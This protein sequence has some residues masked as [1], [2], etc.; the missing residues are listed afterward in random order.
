MVWLGSSLRAPSIRALKPLG[1]V[2]DARPQPPRRARTLRSLVLA[3]SICPASRCH[4]E[5]FMRSSRATHFLFRR[6]H[7]ESRFV[8]QHARFGRTTRTTASI[9]LIDPQMKVDRLRGVDVFRKLGR[10]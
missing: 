7:L 5:L 9:A 4:S 8:N 6:H 3:L 10:T 2:D 1:A